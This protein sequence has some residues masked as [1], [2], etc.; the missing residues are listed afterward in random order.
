MACTSW[1]NEFLLTSS[2]AALYG[3]GNPVVW[4][5]D[6]EVDLSPWSKLRPWR[7]DQVVGD[8]EADSE[9]VEEALEIEV[10]VVEVVVVDSVVDVAEGL[11]DVADSVVIEVDSVVAEVEP[12]VIEE[13]A[14]LE[15]EETTLAG[16]LSG[17]HDLRLRS[18][19]VAPTGRF[20]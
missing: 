13:V 12:L 14:G 7:L 8:S 9:V 5:V 20:L 4:V 3:D 6:L 11:E 2:A 1:A 19:C 18:S 10:V 16:E 17:N 15:E